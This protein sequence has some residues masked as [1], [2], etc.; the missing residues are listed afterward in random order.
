MMQVQNPADPSQA[1]FHSDRK[2][3]LLCFHLLL[4]SETFSLLNKC[5][6]LAVG[7][8]LHSLIA[9]MVPTV[10]GVHATAFNNNNNSSLIKLGSGHLGL[11]LSTWGS[12]SLLGVLGLSL[13]ELFFLLELDY[14]SYIRYSFL[15]FLF[16][17]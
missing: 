3:A 13:D 16:F 15:Y 8:N 17:Y 5:H 9:E 14:I 1:R 7:I 10:L 12:V 6:A 2:L 4:S 11:G